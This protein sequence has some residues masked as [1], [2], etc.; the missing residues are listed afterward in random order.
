ML[1]AERESGLLQ[2]LGFKGLLLARGFEAVLR[3]CLAWP[4]KASLYSNGIAINVAFIA[5]DELCTT[6]APPTN[7]PKI[8][9]TLLDKGFTKRLQ[10]LGKKPYGKKSSGFRA[11]RGLNGPS[12]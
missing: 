9:Q 7:P 2:G 10:D 5:Y 4:G 8:K 11:P 6:F 3:C 12:T 1:K